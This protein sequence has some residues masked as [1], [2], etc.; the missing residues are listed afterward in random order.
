MPRPIFLFF[1][2]AWYNLIS[3]LD[4]N[5][6]TTL[7][8]YGYA[9]GK[10]ER[11]DADG[12]RLDTRLRLYEEITDGYL[13]RSQTIL[14]VGSGRGGG[15]AHLA[16]RYHPALYVGMDFSNKAISFCTEQYRG[17]PNLTF[18][19]GNAEAMPF[20]ARS[21]SLI[22]NVESSHGYPHPE[23]FFGE[24]SR[25]LTKEGVFLYTDFRKPGELPLWER[26]LHAAGFVIKKHIDITQNVL[27]ALDEDHDKKK[28][29]IDSH[30]PYGF[31]RIFYNFAGTRGSSIYNE[32]AEGKL[33]YR[34][35][36]LT[37][38]K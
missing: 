7:M 34:R 2:H 5:G 28:A 33:T 3:T 13:L 37:L 30:V 4:A 8:N 26:Q 21:F 29:L 25:V 35:F 10:S 11:K 6:H 27:R 38:K 18:T 22:L 15:A 17:I 12:K 19:H 23:K 31:R 16:K 32:F 20:P 9:D 14:E 1:L 36:V 24:V